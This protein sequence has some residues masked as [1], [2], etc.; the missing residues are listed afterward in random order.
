VQ[1]LHAGLHVTELS[2]GTMDRNR[3]SCVATWIRAW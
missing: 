3:I 2:D 1:R